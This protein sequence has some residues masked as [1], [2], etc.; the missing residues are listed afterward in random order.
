ML[1]NRAHTLL[2]AFALSFTFSAHASE[3]SD[4]LRTLVPGTITVESIQERD[5]YL[6][7]TGVAPDNAEISALMRAIGQ[8]RLG[9]PRL[10]NIN[11]EGDVSRFHLR[12]R[13]L[14]QVR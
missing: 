4:K 13:L 12:V 3:S 5:G 8:S 1:M 6:D 14:R 7:L 2:A 10:E 9:D 11:R